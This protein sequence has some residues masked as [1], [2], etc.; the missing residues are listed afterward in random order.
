MPPELKEFDEKVK[1][2]KKQDDDLDLSFLQPADEQALRQSVTRLA[3][4]QA[5]R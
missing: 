5:R 4:L 2:K 1:S 3:L